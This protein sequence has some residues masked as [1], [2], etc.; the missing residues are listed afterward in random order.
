MKN[1]EKSDIKG[2]HF[3][4]PE[5]IEIELMKILDN[6]ERDYKEDDSEPFYNF[7]WIPPFND[8]KQYFQCLNTQSLWFAAPN[9]SFYSL[10]ADFLLTYL[11]ARDN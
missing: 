8:L 9:R 3:M 10:N 4:S 5:S 11:I 6:L 2:D 1:H 7:V